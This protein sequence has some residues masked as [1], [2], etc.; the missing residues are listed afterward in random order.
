MGAKLV[1]SRWVMSELRYWKGRDLPRPLPKK[2]RPPRDA[3]HSPWPYPREPPLPRVTNLDMKSRCCRSCTDGSSIPELPGFSESPI[4][5]NIM[6]I[7]SA[8]YVG[9]GCSDGLM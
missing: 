1:H 6:L 9:D 2:L 3:L 7:S 5:P 4:R 8:V